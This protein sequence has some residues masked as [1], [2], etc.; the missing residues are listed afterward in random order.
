MSTELGEQDNKEDNN[1]DN[2]GIEFDGPFCNRVEMDM[3]KFFLDNGL[4]D[5]LKKEKFPGLGN[6]ELSSLGTLRRQ[7]INNALVLE[8]SVNGSLKGFSG[9]LGEGCVD[10][11]AKSNR[12][13]VTYLVELLK[14]TYID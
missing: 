3:F 6:L 2:D 4:I 13:R 7:A 12:D 14:L 10:N 8:A 5:E 9:F 1:N 11:Q